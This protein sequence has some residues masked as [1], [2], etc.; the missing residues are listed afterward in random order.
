MCR[1]REKKSFGLTRE[2]SS[3]KKVLTQLNDPN[4]VDETYY[5]KIPMI[6]GQKIN[7][8]IDFSV[9]LMTLGVHRITSTESILILSGANRIYSSSAVDVAHL[10]QHSFS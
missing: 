10:I 5:H 2:E 1:K 3:G 6:F 9:C 8:F 4:S 7:G